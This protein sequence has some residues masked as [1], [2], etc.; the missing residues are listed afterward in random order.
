MLSLKFYLDIEPTQVLKAANSVSK[1]SSIQNVTERQTR[2]NEAVDILVI[3]YPFW[4]GGWGA[5]EGFIQI[6]SLFFGK[7]VFR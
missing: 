4:W 3:F 6:I 7:S 5:G 1:E 2:K